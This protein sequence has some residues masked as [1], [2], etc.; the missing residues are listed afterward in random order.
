MFHVTGTGRFDGGVMVD[1]VRAISSTN[2]SHT[3]QPSPGTGYPGY[4]FFEMKN[5][6]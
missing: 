1:G 3:A 6:A 4:G 2:T 5:E